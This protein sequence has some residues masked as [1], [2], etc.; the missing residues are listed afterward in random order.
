MTELLEETTGVTSILYERVQ[1]FDEETECMLMVSQPHLD[2]D[3]WSEY[4]RGR[5]RATGA[6]ALKAHSTSRRWTRVLTR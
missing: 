6:T 2:P 4:G 3:L 1:W 5:S